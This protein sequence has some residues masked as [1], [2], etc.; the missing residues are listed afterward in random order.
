MLLIYYF[1]NNTLDS[2]LLQVFRLQ[3]IQEGRRLPF[4]HVRS[5]TSQVRILVTRPAKEQ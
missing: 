1:T 2:N 4:S 5:S 3:P